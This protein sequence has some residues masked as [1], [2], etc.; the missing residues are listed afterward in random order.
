MDDVIIHG[1]RADFRLI[2]RIRNV[3]PHGLDGE[4]KLVS[5]PAW[6]VLEAMAQLAALHVR[7]LKDFSC[8]AFLMKVTRMRLPAGQ[9]LDGKMSLEARLRHQSDRTFSYR[10]VAGIGSAAP[11]GGDILISTVDYDDSF[12]QA[13]LETHYR[14]L[15]ACLLN[16]TRENSAASAKPVSFATPRK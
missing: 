16:A 7:Y 8:H 11:L 2:D 6:C 5:E 13:H 4:K 14:K 9:R 10:V 15:F 3:T 1:G 12:K